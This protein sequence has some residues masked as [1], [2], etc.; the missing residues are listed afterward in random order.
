MDTLDV[1]FIKGLARLFNSAVPTMSGTAGVGAQTYFEDF[2][3]M[4]AGMKMNIESLSERIFFRSST[5]NR[6]SAFQESGISSD[7]AFS[8]LYSS[9]V[10]MANCGLTATVGIGY[11]STNKQSADK[12]SAINVSAITNNNLCNSRKSN[13]FNFM[14]RS[15]FREKNVIR[16]NGY[17]LIT[18]D[19][20]SSSHNNEND[21]FRL[22]NNQG[23]LHPEWFNR[24]GAANDSHS[25]ALGLSSEELT[26]KNQFHVRFHENLHAKS[27]HFYLVPRTDNY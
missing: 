24:Q 8:D 25:I 7:V 23:S 10:S 22:N 26:D 13:D 16:F 9:P 6:V 4:T 20:A 27:R 12:F 19:V 18:A 14:P 17:Q 3:P 5:S 21:P 11:S 1:I 2:D 15:G